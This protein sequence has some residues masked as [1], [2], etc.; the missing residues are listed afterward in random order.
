VTDLY[1]RLKELGIDRDRLKKVIDNDNWGALVHAFEVLTVLGTV[2]DKWPPE[3]T[4]TFEQGTGDRELLL[5]AVCSCGE[6][7]SAWG[8]PAS[9]NKAWRDH[10]HAKEKK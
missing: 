1:A 4:I 3:H 6:Y 2:V 5:R 10:A 9:A 8:T 7:Q